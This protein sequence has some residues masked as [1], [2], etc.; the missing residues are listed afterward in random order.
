[1]FLKEW[2]SGCFCTGIIPRLQ[3]N[4]LSESGPHPPSVKH[5]IRKEIQPV[6]SVSVNL[7]I[8]WFRR[9]VMVDDS[10]DLRV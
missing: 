2:R 7:F 4:A 3:R 8:C 1:M 9:V 6:P 10:R 5:P